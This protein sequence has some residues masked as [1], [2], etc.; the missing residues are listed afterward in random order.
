MRDS[1]WGKEIRWSKMGGGKYST[2]TG[3]PAP[4]LVL[5]K[6][7]THHSENAKIKF[8]SMM[9]QRGALLGNPTPTASQSSRKSLVEPRRA[10]PKT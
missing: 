4:E 9:K 2:G 1:P 5:S 3:A 7:L 10:K 8:I 6:L